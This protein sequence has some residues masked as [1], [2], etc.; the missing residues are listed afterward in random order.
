MKVD[1]LPRAQKALRDA[2]PAVQKAFFKQ[3]KLL[4]GF[5]IPRSALRNMTRLWIGG[6][7]E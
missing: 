5:G 3:V 7:H 6:R 4:E 1:Y 2:P